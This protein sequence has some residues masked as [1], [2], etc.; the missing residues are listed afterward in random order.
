M[1]PEMLKQ[2]RSPAT[3]D[4]KTIANAMKILASSPL[5]FLF[6]EKNSFQEN[7]EEFIDLME[8]TLTCENDKLPE[9]LGE[10]VANIENNN[11]SSYILC[12]LWGCLAALHEGYMI[13]SFGGKDD[14]E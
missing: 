10:L 11:Y 2:R 9:N 3:S 1:T 4:H 12:E 7:F 6:G 8:K 14:G 5:E 13:D